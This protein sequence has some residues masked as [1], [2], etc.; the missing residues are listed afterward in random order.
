M[1]QNPSPMRVLLVDDDA[2]YRDFLRQLLEEMGATDIQE[3]GDGRE[4]RRLLKA[5]A[6]GVDLIVCDVFMPDMDGM[7]FLNFLLRHNYRGKLTMVS[8][9]DRMILEVARTFA[10]QSGLQLVG[11]FPKETVTSALLGAILKFP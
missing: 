7:E 6:N 8:S 2:I 5:S 10:V 1:L 3:A 9:G 4:A 11:A